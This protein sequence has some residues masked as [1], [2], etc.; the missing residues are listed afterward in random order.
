M[1]AAA[2]ADYQNFHQALRRRIVNQPRQR[3]SI[4]RLRRLAKR[5]AGKIKLSRL[6]FAV[7]LCAPEMRKVNI[8]LVGCGT[9]GS[10]VVKGLARNG[11]LMGSR[12]GVSFSLGGVAH[13]GEWEPLPLGENR[14]YLP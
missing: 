10:G 5:V 3:E 12:L 2:C 14:R 13:P 11:A 9:V 4:F 6:G 8:G 1:F 7:T